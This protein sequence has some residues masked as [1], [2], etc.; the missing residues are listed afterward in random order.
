MSAHIKN[1][2]DHIICTHPCTWQSSS[3]P[4]ELTL[5]L[6][7]GRYEPWVIASRRDIPWHDVRFRGY[8]QNKIVHVAHVNA[9]GFDFVVHPTA[10]IIHRAH[11]L[12]EAR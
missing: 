8:G 1:T 3:N 11:A 12:T 6:A 9:S 7:P 2:Y 4:R 10:F 5:L